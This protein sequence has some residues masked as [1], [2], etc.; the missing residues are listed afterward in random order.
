MVSLRAERELGA[1]SPLRPQKFKVSTS[2]LSPCLLQLDM[3]PLPGSPRL[4]WG[5][6]SP[7]PLDS[8]TSLPALLSPCLELQT[9]HLRTC[10]PDMPLGSPLGFFSHHGAGGL[11]PEIQSD[12]EVVL[13]GQAHP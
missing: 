1:G 3:P 11:W 8:L 6:A 5:S 7:Y 12:Q 13:L 10:D 9:G 4:F 2:K